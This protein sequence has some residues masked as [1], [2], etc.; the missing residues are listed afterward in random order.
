MLRTSLKPD[1]CI[2][3]NENYTCAVEGGIEI[4]WKST[5]SARDDFEH[6]VTDTYD[7][8]YVEKNGF[9]VSFKREQLYNFY[10]MLHVNDLELNGT[11]LTCEGVGI[12]LET[13]NLDITKHS[14]I[15]CVSGEF[16]YV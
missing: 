13:M 1:G 11:S 4:A 10:S 9:Q 16:L 12:N 5:V 3:P 7:D 14:L 8:K 2:C 15:I 6:S